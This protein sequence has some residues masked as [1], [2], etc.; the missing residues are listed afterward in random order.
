MY[1]PRPLPE[2]S[3]G[4][5]EW[6]WVPFTHLKGPTEEGGAPREDLFYLHHGLHLGLNAPRN[7]DA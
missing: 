1:Q 3:S 7:A 5:R 4:P 2:F 6:A